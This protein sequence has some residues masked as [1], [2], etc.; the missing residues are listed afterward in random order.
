MNMAVSGTALL[1]ACAA[2]FAYDLY[3]FRDTLERN[4]SIQAQ[5]IGANTTSALT[6]N[7]PT[8][9]EVTLSA[10]QASPNILSATVYTMDGQAFATYRR[11]DA[12]IGGMPPAIPPGQMQVVSFDSSELKL[13]RWILLDGKPTGIVY[14]R[15]DLLELKNRFLSYAGIVAGVLAASLLAAWLISSLSRRTISNPIIHLASVANRVSKEKNYGVRAT[16]TV[17]RGELATLINAFNEMLEQIQQR[18]AA[19]HKAQEELERRVDERTAQLAAAN[20]ELEAFSYS[21]SHDLR[22]PLR[23][24]DGFSSVLS[25]K[26]GATLD[27]TAQQYLSRIREGAK[28]MGHLID[29]LLSMARIGRQAAI[30]KPTD[31]APL[32]NNV[33][34]SLKP[35]CEGRR[36]DWRIKPL[37]TVECDPG[38]MKIVFANLLSNA[39]KYT[40]RKE[41]AT[42]EVGEFI[43]DGAHVIYVR[44]N[45]AGFEQTYAD[46]LFGVF[47]RLHRA[48]DFEGTGVGL[49][50]VRRIIDKHGGR[51]W[52][53]GKVDDGAT[54]FFTLKPA[55]LKEVTHA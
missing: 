5:I 22:A 23:H 29:D 15:S 40:R 6:F 12:D 16:Q 3:T 4:R 2:F 28:H 20:K 36:I 52:A 25:Q 42:I 49:A 39:V 33:I 8:S 43:E 44:D 45:G 51:I 30:M 48:E 13:A 21:V 37:P 55:E 9:A 11:W 35:E 26:Y 34:D 14:I 31:P 1:L 27:P 17:E 38:L 54:F 50:T 7:E 19:L 18:D 41:I 32:V 53:Q 46:K 10:L 24:I 47:Q